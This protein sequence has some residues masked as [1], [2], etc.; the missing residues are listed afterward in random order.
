MSFDIIKKCNYIQKIYDPLKSELQGHFLF[1]KLEM[2]QVSMFAE[3]QKLFFT[4]V[5]QLEMIYEIN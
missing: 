3:P 1:M 4:T 5:K 2:L